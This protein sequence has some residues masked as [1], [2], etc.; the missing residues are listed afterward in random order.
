[1]L[2]RR[3]HGAALASLPIQ[4][5]A[6][7][8]AHGLIQIEALSALVAQTSFA[9]AAKAELRAQ[10]HV[11]AARFSREYQYFRLALGISEVNACFQPQMR[12][13]GS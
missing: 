11:R 10:A 4:I 1:M 5:P 9:S 2:E 8:I 12:I 7:T 3:S 13:F 6:A